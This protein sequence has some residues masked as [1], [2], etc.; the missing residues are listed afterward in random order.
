VVKGMIE[1]TILKYITPVQVEDIPKCI[2]SCCIKGSWKEA[3]RKNNG[4]G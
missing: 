4:R 2:E 3:V 1:S